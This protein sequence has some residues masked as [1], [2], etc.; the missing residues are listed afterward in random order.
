MKGSS[1]LLVLRL[2]LAAVF[3][4]AGALKVADPRAFSDSVATFRLLPTSLI[5]LVAV[6]LPMLEI[7]LGAM[8]FWPRLARPAALGILLLSLS[9]TAAL[10]SGW[11]RGLPIDCG[12]FGQGNWSTQPT[13]LL[14]RNT[15][16]V[17]V[18]FFIY[19][20]LGKVNGHARR[21]LHV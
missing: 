11:L 5:T 16:L 21:P 6:S 2:G 10:I 15:L 1:I 4:F 18:A 8:L 14:L 13:L 9:F 17:V 12:C 3:L 20:R 19:S 7:M